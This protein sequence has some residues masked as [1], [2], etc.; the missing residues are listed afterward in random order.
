MQKDDIIF[1][2]INKTNNYNS[3]YAT[4]NS[5]AKRLV[6]EDE[7]IRPIFFHDTDR[8]L[9]TLSFSRYL[10]KTQVFSIKEN[11]HISRRM[12]HV[13][14]V[15]KIARTIGRALGL[16]EDLIEAASLGHDL[17][18]T[19]LGHAGEYIL[20]KISLENNEGYFNH[21][22]QSVRALMY[23]ENYGKGVNLSIQTLDA[24]LCHNGEFVSNKLTY[25]KKTEKE[26][27][28]EY[29]D[30]Y[31]NKDRIKSLKPMT[32][33]GCVVRICDIIGYLGRD[34]ED[35]LRLKL[36]TVDDIPKD[37][38]EVLGIKNRE[39]ISKITNDIIS[40]SF[41]KT[42]IA[43]SEEVYRAVKD[44]KDFNYHN[45]YLKANSEE[46]MNNYEKM[47]REL[48]DVLLKQLE[49]KDSNSD[50]IN[51]YLK[52]LSEYY[53]NNNSGARKVIDY[54]SG[55]TDNFFVK[56]YEKYVIKK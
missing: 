51:S 45:I 11:D 8:I 30:T 41:D 54:I 17:G 6:E 23:I 46:E 21:N 52:N 24:I 14:F 26:F 38:K 27:L 32:L 10:D 31:K 28:E 36:I 33:E 43:M 19:P 2:R 16:N 50:F 29:Y 25:V 5:D 55:M 42:Y 47:F 56:Q 49:S 44:L 3:K 22:V 15:S 9:Y 18:H 48:F 53:N 4:L 37:I 12:M 34:I 35:A 39:I 7:D 40:N 1:N 13:Q 20:N